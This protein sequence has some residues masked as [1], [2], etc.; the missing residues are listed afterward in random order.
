[1]AKLNKADLPEGYDPYDVN[2]KKQIHERAD[3]K[4]FIEPRGNSV[5]LR[6]GAK[7]KNKDAFCKQ[8]AGFGTDHP[9][10]G[11]CKFCGG[12][13]TGPKTAEGKAKAAQNGRKHGFYSKVLSQEERDTYEELLEDKRIGLEDEIYMMKAKIL[14]YLSRYN[15]KAKAGYSA[16]IEWFKEGDEKGY[17]HAGTI[18]DRT[19]TRA[20]E[21]LRRL[22]D[23]YA[24]LTGNDSGNILDQINA[25]L[26]QASQ[27]QSEE[28]WGGPAQQRK[29]NSS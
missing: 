5:V 25:E 12:S 21:T 24:K 17:Y 28:S 19:L 4:N 1:M 6:C 18:E 15:R 11:R 20:L 2:L 7:R 9:G 14:S 27:K 3:Q 8:L 16:T 23:S 22:V 26:R 29:D 10:F 13:N